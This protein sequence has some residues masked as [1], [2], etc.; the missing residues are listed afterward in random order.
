MTDLDKAPAGVVSLGVGLREAREAQ[1]K[2]LDEAAAITRISKGYLQALEEEEF[3]RLPNPAYVRGFLR[4]YAAFL[5]LDGNRV[6]ALYDEMNA[7]SRL[8]ETRPASGNE[9]ERQP[10][11]W[12]RHGRWFVPAVLLAIVAVFS[13]FFGD[14][15]SAERNAVPAIIPAPSPAVVAQQQPISSARPVPAA[16]TPLPEVTAQPTEPVP[17]GGIVLR[18]KVVQDSGLVMT[19]DDS[20]SQQYELKAGDLIEWKGERSFA[21]ELTNGGAVEAEFNGKALPPLGEPGKT[22]SLVLR[23]G[24]R[25]P[26]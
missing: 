6:V 25:Q 7:T 15:E 24:E 14:E 23:A 4:S 3:D 22:A 5:G 9:N 20:I 12:R 18:L 8:R 11:R 19:I 2:S 21:L 17:R 1:A 16:A 10:R 13:V 26:E